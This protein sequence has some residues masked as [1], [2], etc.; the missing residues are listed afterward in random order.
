[1]LGCSFETG[2]LCFKDEI[3]EACSTRGNMRNVFILVGK[4]EGKDH[5]GEVS[6]DGVGIKINFRELDVAL[7]RSACL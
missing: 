5:L 1:M 6:I 3:G 7:I 4:P 2:I